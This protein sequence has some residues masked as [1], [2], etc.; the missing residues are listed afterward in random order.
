ML[1]L[2]VVSCTSVRPIRTTPS[3]SNARVGHPAYEIS[4]PQV[5]FSRNRMRLTWPQISRMLLVSRATLW[6]R[7]RNTQSFSSR[8]YYSSLTDYDLYELIGEIRRGFPNSVVHAE[9]KILKD[10]LDKSITFG[11][12]GFGKI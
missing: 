1:A 3:A 12:Y 7:V 10:H 11:K 9:Y 8:C 4:V 5:E 2:R 6:R